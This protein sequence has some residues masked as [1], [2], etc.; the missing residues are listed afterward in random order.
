MTVWGM[1][2]YNGATTRL[3]KIATIN[4]VQTLCWMPRRY[5]CSSECQ[6]AHWRATHPQVDTHLLEWCEKRGGPES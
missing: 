4:K 2:Q 5:D 1:R 6:R 3:A